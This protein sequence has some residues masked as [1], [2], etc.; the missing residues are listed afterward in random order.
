MRVVVC[1]GQ[2]VEGEVIGVVG[3]SVH[4]SLFCLV[5]VM[6]LFGRWLFCPYRCWFFLSL[7]CLSG[8]CFYWCLFLDEARPKWQSRLRFCVKCLVIWVVLPWR[9]FLPLRRGSLGWFCGG[10]GGVVARVW[11]TWG[12]YGLVWM[13]VVDYFGLGFGVRVGMI[14][15]LELIRCRG[16]WFLLETASVTRV[17]FCRH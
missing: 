11:F 13:G 4:Y 14:C 5:A 15:G 1:K 10:D 8:F 3:C 2:L 6:A 16:E 9:V 12:C 7:V 17:L